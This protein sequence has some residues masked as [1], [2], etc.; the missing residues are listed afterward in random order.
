MRINLTVDG[1]RIEATLND[2]AAARDFATLLPLTLDLEDFARTERVADLP[3]K[4]STEG[5][6][7]AAE[8]KAGDLGHFAPWGNLA[9]YYRDGKPFDGLIILGSLTHREDAD[10]LAT[11]DRVLIET[12]P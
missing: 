8:P 12:V 10:R 4:L 3:R 11:A 6:P 2:S 9:L 1:Q 7:A 5:A